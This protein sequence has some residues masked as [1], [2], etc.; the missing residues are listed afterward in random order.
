MDVD[1][2]DQGSLGWWNGFEEAEEDLDLLFGVV[3]VGVGEGR[4]GI[5][6]FQGLRAGLSAGVEKAGIA[7]A[8]GICIGWDGGCYESEL[9]YRVPK[10]SR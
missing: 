8:D 5:V 6:Q 1:I 10:L 2:C 9:V 3:G 7:G 4:Q